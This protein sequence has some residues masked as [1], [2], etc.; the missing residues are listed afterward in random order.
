[1]TSTDICNLALAYLAKGRIT[2]LT[3]QTE[4]ARQC[5][6]HYDHCRK[7]LL[8]S[9][10]WGFARRVEKLALSAET[11]P[12]WEFVYGYPST[13][14]SVRFVFREDDACMKE[15]NKD[16]FDIS[17]AGTVKVICTNVEDAWCEY[18]EDVVEVAKMSEEFIEAFAR[19]LAASMAM[20]ITGNAEMMNANYQLM[21]AALQQAQV[22]SALEREQTPKWPTK[23]AEVRFG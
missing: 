10:R 6:M 19:Y 22:E 15:W 2:S 12:G 1:M 18:T 4:E 13:C 11:F 17:V 16:E 3:Q 14:L 20:V 21:Q 5:A 8:R 7:M 23:Y 9:Y